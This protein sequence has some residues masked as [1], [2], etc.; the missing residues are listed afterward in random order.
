MLAPGPA[1][2]VIDEIQALPPPAASRMTLPNTVVS[3]AT[4][5]LLLAGKADDRALAV[6]LHRK[7]PHQ[8]ACDGGYFAADRSARLDQRGEVGSNLPANG[9]LTTATTATLRSGVCAGW[10]ASP[11]DSSTNV[12]IFRTCI[13]HFS[14]Q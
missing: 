8:I 4:R 12:R 10:P 13:E 2:L 11:R 7:R 9:F 14:L 6:A 1:R 3:I 5:M